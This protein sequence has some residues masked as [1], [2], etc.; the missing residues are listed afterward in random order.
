MRAKFFRL[1]FVVGVVVCV[2]LLLAHVLPEE[3]RHER[4]PIVVRLCNRGR[5]VVVQQRAW[6]DGPWDG[7]R[8]R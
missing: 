8:L 4:N 5:A 1:R 7:G 2:L 3:V 6:V